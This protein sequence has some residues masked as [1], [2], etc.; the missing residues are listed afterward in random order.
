MPAVCRPCRPWRDRSAPSAAQSRTMHTG[1]VPLHRP[2]GLY[3]RFPSFLHNRSTA[4]HPSLSKV[5]SYDLSTAFASKRT[6]HGIETDADCCCWRLLPLSS[7]SHLPSI[8]L[9]VSFSTP[10]HFLMR[11]SCVANKTSEAPL[12]NS[13]LVIMPW[14]S[15]G[16]ESNTVSR[17]QPIRRSSKARAQTHIVICIKRSKGV[18][19]VGIC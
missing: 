16:V 7:C 9:T 6:C 13:L 5:R 10:F 14:A 15:R 19:Q 3:C 1:A 17:I 11:S 2:G 12:K 18:L 8:A 4:P